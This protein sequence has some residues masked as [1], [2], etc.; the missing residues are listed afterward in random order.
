MQLSI[1][2]NDCLTCAF[3]NALGL[4]YK[5]IFYSF[6]LIGTNTN[7]LDKNLMGMKGVSVLRA[8]FSKKPMV[9]IYDHNNGTGT[10]HAVAIKG[11]F[12]V[13]NTVGSSNQGKSL[14]HLWRKHCLIHIWMKK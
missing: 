4:S 11:G 13:D 7:H 8:M 10:G 12:C 9:V 5:S 3:V 6:R 1:N 2:R 14:F